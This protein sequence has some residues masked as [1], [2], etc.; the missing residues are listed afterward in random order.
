[1]MESAVIVGKGGAP[2]YWH[3]PAN[4]SS[5][6]IPDSR[7]L[8][9]VIWENRNVIEGLAHTHPGSGKP[10]PSYEDLTT[11]SAI[12]KAIGRKL[13]WWIVTEDDFAEFA[14]FGP[15]PLHYASNSIYN[16]I[17][18]RYDPVSFVHNLITM[19]CFSPHWQL[20]EW[21]AQLR[22]YSYKQEVAL[23]CDG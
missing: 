17:T 11:F 5:I 12:E 4:R 2:I 8:W 6:H 10:N 7:D 16:G 3:L 23:S 13:F 1:M 20:P 19:G 9:E 22:E 21:V 15:G 14:H 18:E